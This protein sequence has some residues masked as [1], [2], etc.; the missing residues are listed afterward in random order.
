MSKHV[1][2]A[3]LKLCADVLTQC[4]VVTIV[5]DFEEGH[6]HWTMLNGNAADERSQ[7]FFDVQSQADL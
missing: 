7:L 3:T 4:A 5:F 2:E 6:K 1:V